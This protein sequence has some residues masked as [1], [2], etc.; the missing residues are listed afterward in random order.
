VGFP[1]TKSVF[2]AADRVGNTGNRSRRRQTL[3]C[4]RAASHLITRIL[5]AGPYHPNSSV[6][7]V[8]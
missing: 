2:W 4:S 6:R 5:P 8:R 3:R 7:G 1:V